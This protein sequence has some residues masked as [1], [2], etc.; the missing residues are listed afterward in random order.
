MGEYSRGGKVIS[1]QHGVLRIVEI[2]V[3]IW[4]FGVRLILL[5]LVFYANGSSWVYVENGGFLRRIFVVPDE[6]TNGECD[7]VEIGEYR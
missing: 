7:V 3:F 2:T 5:F 4:K 1:C 6:A